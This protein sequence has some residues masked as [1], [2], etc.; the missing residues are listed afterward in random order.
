[1]EPRAH[2]ELPL[3]KLDAIGKDF[4]AFHARFASLFSRSEPREKAAEY[5]RALMG[6]VERRNGWQLAEAMGDATPDA[7]ERL[8]YCAEWDHDAARDRLLDFSMEQFRHPEGIGVLDETGFV[9]KGNASVGVAR[10][11]CGVVGKVEN[12]QIGV[13]LSYA[14]PRGH[15]LLDR[16]LYLPHSWCD[17]AA[18]RQR[19]HVPSDVTF[20]TKP[21]LALEMLHHAWDHGVPMAWITGDE[22]Y[23][24][25]PTFRAGVDEA[26]HRY[27]L[28]VASSTPAWTTRPALDVPEPGSCRKHTRLAAGAPQAVTVAKVTAQWPAE[29]WQRIAVHQGEKGPVEYDWAS[30]RVV[31]SRDRLP[32][33]EVWLLVRR[34]VSNPSEMA[35]YLSNADPTTPLAPLARAASTRYTVEQCFEEAKDDVGLD[36]YEVRNWPSWH[37]HVTLSMMAHVWLASVRAKLADP[38]STLAREV[39]LEQQ[40]QPVVEPKPVGEPQPVAAQPHVEPQPQEGSSASF[41]TQKKGGPMA[42]GLGWRNSLLGRSPRRAA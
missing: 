6:P 13:F 10:Q 26:A 35:Y 29:A 32:A 14:S 37:R 12:C 1:M 36:Q 22:V 2:V 20:K 31:D 27:V 8:L 21:E 11:Y 23:G 16:R 3:P 28:A 7:V 33:D 25:D 9:K 18:R 4:E 30:A 19:A 15:V 42:G 34:S 38:S 39:A 17:D 40:E 5:I 41:G 24:D